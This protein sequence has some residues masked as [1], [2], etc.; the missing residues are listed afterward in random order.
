MTRLDSASG[1]LLRLPWLMTTEDHVFACHTK[2]A[3]LLDSF[4]L[5]YCGRGESYL[6]S[7]WASL[8]VKGLAVLFYG[9]VWCA[10]FCRLDFRKLLSLRFKSIQSWVE[11]KKEQ[12]C[13]I[14]SWHQSKIKH[15]FFHSLKVLGLQCRP[16]RKI[17]H[18][19]KVS[20]MRLHRFRPIT[21]SH[22]QIQISH[23]LQKP[24]H[25]RKKQRKS[26]NM[27]KNVDYLN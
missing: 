12:V 19:Q 18:R 5:T 6:Y 17:M 24:L 7:L 2:L 1:S 22:K 25:P 21:N 13:F 26:Y 16:C 9:V 15:N 27:K 20:L 10:W 14:A 8:L 11:L 3:I 4:F 23:L